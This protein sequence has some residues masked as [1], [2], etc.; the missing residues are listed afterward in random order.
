MQVLSGKTGKIAAVIAAFVSGGSAVTA[1]PPFGIWP[2]MIAAFAVLFIICARARSTAAAAVYGWLFGFGYHLFG[3]YWIGNALLV[4]GNDY[5]WAWPLAVICLPLMLAFFPAAALFVAKYVGG[6]NRLALMLALVACVAGAEWLRGHILTGFPWNLPAYAWSCVLPVMQLAATGGSYF[7]SLMTV[8]WGAACG[9]AVLPGSRR[10]T[11]LAVAFVAVA[12]FAASC[13]YGSLRIAGAVPEENRDL[14]VQIVQPSI[15]Q[16]DKWRK[17]KIWD[18]FNTLVNMSYASQTGTPPPLTLVVWPETAF[19]ERMLEYPEARRL[20]KDALASHPGGAYLVSGMLRSETAES[21]ARKYFNSLVVLD[22]ELDEI[23]VYDKRHLVPF[24]E[25]IPMQHLLPLEPVARFTGM[26]MGKKAQDITIDGTYA[27]SPRICYEIIFPGTDASSIYAENDA[28]ELV[29]RSIVNVTNDAW[30]GD[31]SGPFQHYMTSAFRA[32]E[33]RSLLIRAA[34]TGISGVF[35]PYGREL[36]DMG[37]DEQ[38]T[39]VIY[40]VPRFRSEKTV[41]CKM[42]DLLFFLAIVLLGTISYLM[43]RLRLRLE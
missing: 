20:L 7:L 13:I 22:R 23:A 34:N 12:C 36:G 30:Y 40:P 15:P 25:Y 4:E 37:L 39:L 43:E 14:A 38:G 29:S 8:F 19:Q 41:Y 17:E 31:S 35:D 21:G 5:S 18:N 16:S 33:E 1:L 26:A 28:A 6:T 9:F 3:L 27:L 10:V 24:G 32:I 2:C 11:R 42:G